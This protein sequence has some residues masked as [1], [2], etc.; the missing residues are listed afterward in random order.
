MRRVVYALNKKKQR[1]TSFRSRT[2]YSKFKMSIHRDFLSI[3]FSM[4]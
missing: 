4:T 1:Q 2:A 3:Y